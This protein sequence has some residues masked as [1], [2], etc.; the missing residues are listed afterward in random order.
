MRLVGASWVLADRYKRSGFALHGSIAPVARDPHRAVSR[1]RRLRRRR[2]GRRRSSGDRAS[3]ATESSR[4][5]RDLERHRHVRFRAGRR[6]HRS[7]LREHAREPGPRR[8]RR[9][10]AGRKRAREHDDGRGGGVFLQRRPKHERRGPRPRA[11]D[12][13][14]LS[15]LGFSRRGQYQRRRAVR[16]RWH[17]GEHRHS[18]QHAQSARG[19]RLGRLG[20]YGRAIRGAVRDPRYGV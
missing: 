18:Q 7:R 14:G 12:S 19:F 2:R 20:L 1:A 9:A 4:R 3:A 10:R 11:N 15:E 17:G 6:R 13:H 8:D 5:Q 16:A